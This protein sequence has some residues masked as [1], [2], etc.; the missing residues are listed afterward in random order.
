MAGYKKYNGLDYRPKFSSSE[1]GQSRESHYILGK[2]GGSSRGRRR[3][4][5]ISFEDMNE[6]AS[7]FLGIVILILWGL[8]YLL[9]CLFNI[10]KYFIQYLKKRRISQRELVDIKKRMIGTQR[11]RFISLKCYVQFLCYSVS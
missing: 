11:L 4:S 8:F 7:L 2:I 6:A 5:D 1:K 10:V 9:V 3:K